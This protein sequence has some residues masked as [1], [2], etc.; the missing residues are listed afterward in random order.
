MNDLLWEVQ[1]RV[2]NKEEIDSV[3]PMDLR[4]FPSSVRRQLFYIY[5]KFG[6]DEERRNICSRKLQQH[7]Y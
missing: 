1:K 4:G 3:F 5:A 2:F 6:A 7:I